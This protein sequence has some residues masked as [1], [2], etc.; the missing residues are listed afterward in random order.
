LGGW[1]INGE[2]KERK[3]RELGGPVGKVKK[4]KKGVTQNL[5]AKN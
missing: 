3:K 2:K 1:P 4:W 5:K